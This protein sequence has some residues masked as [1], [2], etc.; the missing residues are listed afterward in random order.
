MHEAEQAVAPQV[1]LPAALRVV[2]P[3][4]EVVVLPVVRQVRVLPVVVLPEQEVA[5]ALP[6]VPR[7]LRALLVAA[8]L[9]D[10]VVVGRQQL[11]VPAQPQ[12]QRLPRRWAKASTVSPAAMCR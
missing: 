10:S 1:V 6:V 3:V 2:L 12:R 4:H 8:L 5:A 11:A 7:L 9:V